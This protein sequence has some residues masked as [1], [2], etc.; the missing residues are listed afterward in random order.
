MKIVALIPYWNNYKY[1][2]RSMVNRDATSLSG[3]ILL[4]YS[5]ELANKTT[6]INRTCLFTNDLYVSKL[7][8]ERLSYDVIKRNSE[9][10]AQ[11]VSI[12]KI[13]S[14][15]LKLVEADVIVLLH[16]KSPFLSKE[17]L[18]Q[19]IEAVVL[20]GFDSAF[21]AREERKFAWFDGMRV[22]YECSSGTPHLSD[23]KPIILETSSAYVFTKSFFIN[24]GTRISKNPFIK[25]VGN[26]EGMTI[27]GADDLALAQ[28]LQDSQYSLEG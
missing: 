15:F 22:N 5:I 7:L 3:K 19:C 27:S 14:D 20:N 26:F 1:E 17:S 6:L 25:I 23:I 16:P 2:T 4:N 8:D 12:E 28:F 11:D 24:S 13:I 18:S 21:V 10:D 9:L